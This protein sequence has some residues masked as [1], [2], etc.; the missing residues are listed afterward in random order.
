[1]IK[2]ALFFL[3]TCFTC[4]SAIAQPDTAIGLPEKTSGLRISLLT[5]GTGEEIFEVFGHTAIRVVDSSEPGP[6]GDIVYNYGMFNGYA[7][8][9]E[10]KFMRG[11]LLYYVATNLFP[12]FMEEYQDYGRSVEEQ[13]L[14]LDDDKKLEI[15]AYLKQNVLPENR[16]YK[17]DF[18]FDNC[19]TRIR[20]IFPRTLGKD[21]VFAETRPD[22]YKPTFRDIINRYFHRE[23]WTRVGVNILLGSKIDRVMTNEDIMFL[24]DYLRDGLAGATLKGQK[25]T[26]P[27]QLLL[28]GV[29]KK[30]AGTNMPMLVMCMVLALTIAGHTVKKLRVLG[31]IMR[32][33]VL[34]VSGFLGCL[35]FVMWFATDH[36]GCS[37]N[38]N[39]LWALP[40]NLLLVFARPHGKGRYAVIATLLVLIS[41]LV[42]LV[43]AQGLVPEFMPFLASLLVVYGYMYRCSNTPVAVTTASVAPPSMYY[44]KAGT[45]PALVLLHGFP[46]SGTI[47]D[48]I[49]PELSAA[50][51]VI[52]PDLPGSGNTK[53]GKETMLPEMA[54]GI[55][56]ILDFEHIPKAV[57]AG[58]SMGGYVALAFA[59]LYPGYVS[60]LSLVHSTPAADDDEKKAARLK[61]IELVRNGGKP[62]FIKQ[63]TA[64]LF[65]EAFRTAN[66]RKMNEKTEAG[67]RISDEGLINF[68]KA[69][70]ARE[71]TTALVKSA[72]FPLQWIAGAHDGII[73]YKKTLKDCHQSGINFVALY[74][75]CGHI[76]IIEDP[77]KLVADLKHFSDYCFYYHT[78]TG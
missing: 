73:N 75:D 55:K 6:L 59:R 12:D 3:L 60:G 23:H 76:S 17:Y 27:V 64:N 13:V 56:Q 24:P 63:M 1:M 8:N 26:T 33:L 7:E 50:Y 18:F 31:R 54:T 52:V 34:F 16:Y 11:K 44:R 78:V 45:G 49:I 21:F 51:T 65:S 28:P 37:N 46:D 22:S 9:F 66:P 48:G 42:H 29:E 25:L 67:L 41:I 43:H 32:G 68:Y 77:A 62:A 14:L 39:L 72:Q 10:L 70:I 5:C 69:M 71:D 38:F 36:Q 53:L 19:A 15:N 57:F 40:V 35:I 4:F 47:W 74:S 61:V 30:P 58:H 20:D 2:R